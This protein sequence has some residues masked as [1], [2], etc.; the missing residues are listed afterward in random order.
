MARMAGV[1][2]EDAALS[3]RSFFWMVRRRMGRLAD[4][5]PI[6]AHVPRLLRGWGLME[7]HLEGLRSVEPRLKK[8]AELKVAVLV[9]CPA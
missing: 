6:V 4:T 5:W 2:R 3:A 1:R 7:L 9:G 8:L